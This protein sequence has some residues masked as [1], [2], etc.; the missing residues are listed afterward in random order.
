MA[1]TAGDVTG[2]PLGYATPEQVQA[3]NAFADLLAQK[4]TANQTIRSPW[5]GISNIVSATM[6]GLEARQA[7][8]AAQQGRDAAAAQRVAAST[9]YAPGSPTATTP[10]VTAPTAATPAPTPAVTAA[11]PQTWNSAWGSPSPA[12]GVAAQPWGILNPP[13]TANPFTG[14]S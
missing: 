12:V 10:T 9:G 7:A 13:V 4:A 3:A 5:Q 6:S 11:T 1:L 2:T 8:K 14:A